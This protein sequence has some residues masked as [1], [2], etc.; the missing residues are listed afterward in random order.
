VTNFFPGPRV[1]PSA[2]AA[3]GPCA[4]KPRARVSGH[5]GPGCRGPGRSPH[6]RSAWTHPGGSQHG[7]G[8]KSARDSTTS[9][10]ADPLGDRDVDR[11]TERRGQARARHRVGQSR[12][13]GGPARSPSAGRWRRAWRLW[14]DWRRRP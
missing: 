7:A 9:P 5:R 10:N 12:R 8:W 2:R 11:R 14:G 4:G 13:P 6:G 3:P 1:R